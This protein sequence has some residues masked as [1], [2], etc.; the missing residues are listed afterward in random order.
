MS[1]RRNLVLPSLALAA[2]LALSACGGSD[3]TSPMNGADHGSTPMMSTSTSAST[4][5]GAATPAAGE[6][7]DA[8]VAFATEMIGHHRQ[9]VD[10]AAMAGAQA[11]SPQVK[12]LA[13]Q[14]EAAQAPEIAQMTTWLTGWG[15]PAPTQ[16]MHHS[17]E[18][19]N[20][21]MTM[22][23]M[24]ALSKAKGGAFDQ[25]F[26]QGMITHHQGALTMATTELTSGANT[27]AKKLAQT[28]QDSQTRE[29]NLMKTL[30]QQ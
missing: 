8:D 29:I 3:E 26:L 22:E 25:I 6:H 23:Q 30:L 5:A 15:A 21:M 10:M 16:G 20:G 2:G 24:D 19:M 12:R 28:I 14:I 7:N 27:E 9:A 4:P 1:T 18:S 17:G 13:A 11:K